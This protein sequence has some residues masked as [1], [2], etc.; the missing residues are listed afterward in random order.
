MS[1]YDWHP[2]HPDYKLPKTC[3]YC[4]ICDEGIQNGEKYIVNDVDDY[5][6]WE[7]IRGAKHLSEWLGYKIKE[8]EE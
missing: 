5:A 7:C 1:R 6:H 3:Y 4:S 2:R 8:M